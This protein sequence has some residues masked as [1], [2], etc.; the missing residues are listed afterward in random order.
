M[1]ISAFDIRAKLR[2]K[3]RGIKIV[4]VQKVLLF[5]RFLKLPVMVA[6]LPPLFKKPRTQNQETLC[7][8]ILSLRVNLAFHVLFFFA[9]VSEKRIQS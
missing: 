5:N 2:V 9:E 6:Y 4:K 8:C 1:H 7:N 3:K